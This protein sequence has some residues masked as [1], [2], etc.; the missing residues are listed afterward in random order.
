MNFIDLHKQYEQLK[1]EID[2]GIQMVLN[3]ASFIMGRQVGEL[4]KQLAD[5]VGTQFCIT[6]GNGTDALIL[7][8]K[9]YGIKPGDAVFLPTFTFYATA[10]VVSACGATPVFVDIDR[11]TYN[12]S[13]EDLEAA[14]EEVLKEGKLSPAAIIAVDLFGLPYDYPR[15]KEL[16]VKYNLLV[17][18]DGAQGF[19]G[20]I[21]GKRA[22]SLGDISTTSFFPS[23][24]LGCYGDGG[25]VFTNEQKVKDH[26]ESLRAH[27]KG[28]DKYDNIRVGMNSRLDTI[29]AAVLLIKL[30]AFKEY[31]QQQRNRVADVYN[32]ILKGEV[33]LPHIPEG[34][35]SSY[36]Q[37]SILLESETQRNKVKNALG[38]KGIPA[39]IY[40]KKSMHQQTVYR[41]NFSIYRKFPNAER[42]SETIL[43]LP[44]DPYLEDSTI[45]EICKVILD[46]R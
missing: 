31:E 6:C 36:A 16:S 21:E 4:E 5:Y 34:Y 26:I 14:I 13:I 8:L 27:G 45:N 43:N 18:E 1:S 41:N 25:A 39:M 17:I 42:V 33:I 46:N 3:E 15:I 44:M 40:Y 29:Q 7:A 30:K 22:C 11:N 20:S 2:Q 24:P 9:A 19:G 12:L 23:K 10:E 38:S 37:Y 32:E 35:V 28:A